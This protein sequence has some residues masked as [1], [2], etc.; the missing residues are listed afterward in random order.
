MIDL[1]VILHDMFN[2]TSVNFLC[3][4]PL[5]Y[6]AG[7]CDVMYIE[8]CTY[9]HGR[10]FLSALYSDIFCLMSSQST[11]LFVSSVGSLHVYATS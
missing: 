11:L 6:T 4:Y 1:K 10:C 2:D 8:V 9:V 3:T 5:L 7:M